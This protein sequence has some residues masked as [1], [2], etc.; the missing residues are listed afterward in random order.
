MYVYI[1]ICEKG[2]FSQD[3]ADCMVKNYVW[4]QGNG[5]LDLSRYLFFAHY[6]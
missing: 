6:R 1:K 3:S 5:R 2:N 4:G